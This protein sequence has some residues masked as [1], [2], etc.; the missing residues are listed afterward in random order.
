MADD[1]E[2]PDAYREN[3]KRTKATTY[4]PRTLQ[5]VKN[6]QATVVFVPSV[7]HPSR[8]AE[9]AVEYCGSLDKPLLVVETRTPHD[10]RQNSFLVR[11]FLH[12]NKPEI[13]NVTGTRE[14][15]ADGIQDRVRQIIL[16]AFQLD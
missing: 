8:G 9:L 16:G 3:L 13:L 7:L 10:V 6:S 2:I 4:P 5:N 11:R 15:K 1:G 14:G 12:I